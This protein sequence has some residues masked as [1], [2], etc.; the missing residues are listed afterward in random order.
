MAAV[1]LDHTPPIAPYYDLFDVHSAI[2]GDSEVFYADA[3]SNPAFEVRHVFL[4][5]YAIL[6]Q[7]VHVLGGRGQ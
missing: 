7:T 3:A 4:S 5:D 2:G 6:C 1:E